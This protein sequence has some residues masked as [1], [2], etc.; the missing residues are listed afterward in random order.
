[1][2]IQSGHSKLISTLAVG[3]ALSVLGALGCAAADGGEADPSLP[4]ESDDSALAQPVESVN[5]AEL[6][7]LEQALCAAGAV[8][9]PIDLFL[10]TAGSDDITGTPNED[11]LG[12]AGCDD[13]VSAAGGDDLL[14]GGAGDDTLNGGGG[15]DVLLGGPGADTLDGS[16]NDDAIFGGAGPDTL[17][18]GGDPGADTLDG[19]C[20][21]EVD[22]MNGGPGQDTCIGEVGLDVFT[23]CETIIPCS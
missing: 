5:E 21:D 12:G 7:Q 3:A 6:G 16:I 8:V 18:G 22:T 13:V 19:G 11:I 2:F 9:G 15:E 4:T 17:N 20:D 14:R 10:G 1:M 23:S